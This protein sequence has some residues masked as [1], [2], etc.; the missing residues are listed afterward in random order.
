M[1]QF[2]PKLILYP[3]HQSQ[4]HVHTAVHVNNFLISQNICIL[5]FHI[6]TIADWKHNIYIYELLPCVW[7]MWPRVSICST[8]SL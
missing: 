4:I 7:S 2:G 6:H 5:M 8:R 3:C 1:Q